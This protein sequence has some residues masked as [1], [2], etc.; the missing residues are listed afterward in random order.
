MTKAKTK[1]VESGDAGLFGGAERRPEA[2]AGATAVTKREEPKQQKTKTKSRAIATVEPPVM[3]APRVVTMFDP[4]Q[5]MAMIERV[6]VNPAVD[7]GKMKELLDLQERL[8]DRSARMAFDQALFEMR[9]ELPIITKDGKIEHEGQSVARGRNYKMAVTYA[10]W[11]TLMPAIDPIIHKFGFLLRH[12]IGSTDDGNRVR[13]TAI[14]TGHGHTDDS[15]YFDLTA[16]TTGSKNNAQ[17]WASSVSYAKRH[18]A[19]AVLN[20]VTKNEDDDGKAGGKPVVIGDPI[21]VDQV[22]RLT[23]YAKAVG[24]DVPRFIEYLNKQ[25]PK[26]HP[27]LTRLEDLPASRYGEATDALRERDAAANKAKAKQQPQREDER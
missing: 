5:V 4:M 15:C 6:A 27:E 17:A 25:R 18:T 16:D 8:M 22:D 3:Q 7:P 14:L 12:R 24:A 23:E 10:K 11:E 19:C 9:P 13:V 1:T 21:D 2:I 20:I 26:G